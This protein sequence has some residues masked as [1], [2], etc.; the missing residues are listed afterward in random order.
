MYVYQ[1][2]VKLLSLYD[3]MFSVVG[4]Y[5]IIHRDPALNNRKNP[6]LVIS[7]ELNTFKTYVDNDFVFK[8]YL[9]KRT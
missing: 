1:F 6:S 9:Y 2:H 3:C 7:F 4:E 8:K 5:C